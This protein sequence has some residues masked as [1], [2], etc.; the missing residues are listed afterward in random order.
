M[1]REPL[2]WRAFA[3]QN[4]IKRYKSD[5]LSGVPLFCLFYLNT[6]LTYSDIICKNT[7]IILI[8]K[9][10][11]IIFLENGCFFYLNIV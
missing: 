3:L 10:F 1:N 9:E 4:P 11:L 7:K 6:V 8:N 2:T 5:R